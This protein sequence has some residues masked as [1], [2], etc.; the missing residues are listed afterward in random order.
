[1]PQVWVGMSGMTMA[2]FEGADERGVMVMHDA[3][4]R[5]K[6]R[7]RRRSAL[8]LEN[9]IRC[10]QLAY[11]DH[12]DQRGNRANRNPQPLLARQSGGLEL[13]QVLR[14]LMQILLV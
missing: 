4:R 6:K 1:M 9:V 13:I 5:G 7:A 2:L 11:S 3:K 8:A 14:E 12:D 10:T